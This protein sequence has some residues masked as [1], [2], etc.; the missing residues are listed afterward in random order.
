MKVLY[1]IEGDGGGAVTHVLT[2]A[3]ELIKKDIDPVIAFLLPGHSIEAAETLGLNYRLIPKKRVPDPSLPWRILRLLRREKVDILH[4]HTIRGNFYGRVA[5]F[6]HNQPLISVTTVH[7]HIA[8]ELRGQMDFGLRD[9]LLCKRE[10]HTSRFVDHFI[11]VS[12]KLRDRLLLNHI[13]ASKITVIENGV[14]L[15]DLSF[16]N[17]YNES[18]RREFAIGDD[19]VVVGIIGRLV[20]VKNHHLFVK[21]AKQISKVRANIKFLIIGDGILLNSLKR[22]VVELG[23]GERVI[24]T[25]WRDDIQKILCALDIYVICSIV[26]GLNISVLEA[27]ACGKPVVGTNVKGISEIIVDNETGC[28]VTS[29]DV[30]ALAATVMR[31]A[32]N[33]RERVE[34]GLKGRWLIAEKYSVQTM[35]DRTLEVYKNL[36]SN[37]LVG[38]VK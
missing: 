7:S 4:T 22:K 8:D 21:A 25:G 9:R 26:E 24:F 14:E 28:L 10:I 37:L 3:R 38:R 23:I 16:S 34:M 13:L 2:L 32:N 12:S 30:T 19:E 15:P 29:N 31:L 17:L 5:R 36:Y 20:P 27:M 33:K 18:L 6:L 11:C 35:I 1:L